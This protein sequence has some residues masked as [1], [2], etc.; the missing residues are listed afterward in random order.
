ML[1]Y[2]EKGFGV[3]LIFMFIF[4][5]FNTIVFGLML[6]AFIYYIKMKSYEENDTNIY[7]PGLKNFN[8]IKSNKSIEY[9]PNIPNLGY[10]GPLYL[11]CYEGICKEYKDHRNY[12]RDDDDIDDDFYTDFFS[13]YNFPYLNIK[14]FLYNNLSE[15]KSFIKDNNGD[16]YKEYALY[17]CSRE[18]AIGEDH[19]CKSCP[20]TA[21]SIYGH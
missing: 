2:R 9:T 20:S 21:V 3:Y 6:S 15:F 8:F 11:N 14:G 7:V 1:D 16:E 17:K 19:K 18:C 4:L 10:A 12:D 13:Q 5:I